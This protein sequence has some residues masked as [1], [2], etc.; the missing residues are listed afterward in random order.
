MSGINGISNPV[1]TNE[2]AK[3]SQ[4][5]KTQVSGKVIGSPELSENAAKYYEQLKKKFSNMDFIL[6]SADQKEAAKAQAASY[7]NPH[8]MVV[9]IDEEKI[10]RMA[11]DESFRKQYEGIIQNGANSLAQ[12]AKQITASGANVKGFGMQIK[13]NRAS[14]FAAVDKSFAMQR[15]MQQKRLAEKKAA[16]KKAE[17]K[18]A[19]EEAEERLQESLREKEESIRGEDT[20]AV[21]NQWNPEDV[22]IIS[23][24]SIEELMQKIEDYN[25]Y[26]M[27]NSVQ[28]ESE[29]QLGQNIDFSV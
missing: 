1:Q 21:H 23:A 8:R 24:S 11:E 19:K 3:S 25:F 13:D 6:V 17:K 9:L 7:A 29:R 26:N 20:E 18:A 27:S 10:E 22:E 2:M 14:F 5:E 16:A 4:T 15:E 12:M 28:T